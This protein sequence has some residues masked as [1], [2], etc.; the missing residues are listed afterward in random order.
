[1]KIIKPK[2]W[3]LK[4]TT[5]LSNLL[6]PFTLPLIINNYLLSF[7]KKRE[8]KEIKTICLGN[9]YIGGTGKTPLT[10][11]LD[12]IL[13]ELNFKTATIKKFYTDQVDEQKLLANKSKLYCHKNRFEALKNAIKDN[14]DVAIFDD[15]LQDRYLKY[16]ISFVCF[17][18]N[19]WIGNGRLIP[20]GPLR[21]KLKSISKYDA[22]FL[23]S[24]EEKNF[25][26]YEAIKKVSKSIKIFSTYY[27]PT[28]IHQFNIHDNYL[29]F[30]GIGNPSNFKTTLQKNKFK[31][32][33]EINYPDH[34]N[35]QKKDMEIIK[36]I[37]KSFNAKIITTEKDYVKIPKE[38]INDINF[39]EI[40]LVIKEQDELISFIKS[41]I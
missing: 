18:D 27:K 1:M 37:A 20:S 10:I 28:N 26:I 5:L 38:Y 8:T 23:N 32:I 30:S 13:K 22:I 7:K 36:K 12:Q 9:I 41:K 15:G 17:N 29:A 2:F 11:K 34:Y 24:I 19:N 14:V 35:Y 40:E 21:E 3:D 31:I 25:D 6:L 16:D 4:E 33:K 39:L